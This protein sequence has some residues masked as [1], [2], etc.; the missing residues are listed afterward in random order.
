[1]RRPYL[2]CW[3]YIS[4]VPRNVGTVRNAMPVATGYSNNIR[5]NAITLLL[6]RMCTN[7]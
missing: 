5:Y 2:M 1:M 7:G 6:H 3:L 4:L